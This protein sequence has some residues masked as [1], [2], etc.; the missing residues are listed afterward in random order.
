[1]LTFENVSFFESNDIA[2]NEFTEETTGTLTIDE[3][4][5]K[6]TLD[7]GENRF[8]DYDL[9]SYSNEEALVVLR[10][11]DSFVSFTKPDPEPYNED[12]NLRK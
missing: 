5:G 3:E 11:G 6:A 1:M 8:I 10:F 7:L 4:A 12:G 9:D 2:Y